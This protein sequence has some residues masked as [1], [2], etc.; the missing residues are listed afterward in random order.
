MNFLWGLVR[1]PKL[2]APHSEWGFV[3]DLPDLANGGLHLPYTWSSCALPGHGPHLPPRTFSDCK[4]ATWGGSMDG[5][6][7]A[8]K[9]IVMK[10]QVN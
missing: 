10:L 7:S 2:T 4:A 1:G 6:L 5:C 9:E 3:G 8:P